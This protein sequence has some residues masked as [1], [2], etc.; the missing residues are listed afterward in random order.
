MLIL[1]FIRKCPRIDNFEKQLWK[2]ICHTN[3]QIYTLKISV[4]F[5]KWGI[6][7]EIEKKRNPKHTSLAVYMYLTSFLRIICL[8]LYCLIFQ[9][10]ALD[11]KSTLGYKS[12][13][14]FIFYLYYIEKTL[15][16]SKFLI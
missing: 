10:L 15:H 12:V 4:N 9:C 3:C 13:S 11:M 14:L 7:A 6:G 16:P 2:G 8:C 1:K 5:F